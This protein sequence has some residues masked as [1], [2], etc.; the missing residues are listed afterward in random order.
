[1][2]NPRTRFILTI[3]CPLLLITLSAV[4]QRDKKRKSLEGMPVA[5]RM[6]EAES[7][8]TEG[9]K[10]FILEDYAKALY[11]FQRALELN[12]ENATIHYK[13][14]EILAKGNK[15]DDLLRASLSIETALSLEKKNKYFYILASTIYSGLNNFGQAEQAL[16]TMM[17]EIKGTDEYLY[18]LAALYQYDHK[19]DEAIKVYNRAES[20]LGINEISSTQKQ[21][22][23]L[24]QGKVN[25]AI[26]EGKKLVTA[27]PDDERFVLGLAETF[28]QNKQNAQAIAYLENY[29][30]DHPDAGNAK[31]L[32]AGIYR[33]AGE[34]NKARE[35]LLSAFQDASLPVGSKVMMLGAQVAALG[36]A[37]AKKVGDPDGEA[38]LITL[39][40]MLRKS[41]PNDASVNVVGGDLFLTLKKNAEA[42]RE[43]R[44]AIR[45][46]ST[47]FDA[48][49][50]L[51]YLESQQNEFD[52]VIVHAEQALELFPNQA[53][54]YYFDGF[55]Q[56]R[57]RHY[58]EAVTTLEQ[59]KKLS[60]QNPSLAGD[61]SG[62]LGEAYNGSKDYPKSDQ[63]YDDALAVNPDND[64]VLNNYSY[65]LALRK[66]HLDKAEKMSS[67]L[68]R[69]HPENA[70]YL[71][72]YSWVLYERGKYK[73]AKRIMEKAIGTGNLSAT[74]VEHYGDILFQL[75]NIDEAVKQWQ[76]SKEL[77][78]GNALI[79][80]KIANRKLY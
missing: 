67:R 31:M 50:N 48:W 28:S 12:S 69:S 76:K 4:A 11:H 78:N 49:Q 60:T 71:D 27:F 70:T 72:T 41:N 36:Q 22:L 54:I 26:M 35:L 40:E 33:D 56:L 55:A 43:Y 61:V 5:V 74:I 7:A 23:Y 34:E 25:E 19:P 14:A 6:R 15:Q 2:A 20:I 73:D 8:F 1:L 47:S 18:E 17:E 62:L 79:D 29:L 52:S 13:V 38:F 21:R 24:E 44:T 30:K 3:V 53:M 51:L 39:F 16:Q 63:A 64:L 80:K 42:E 59:A 58:R 77:D 66:E 65:Y 57:K 10:Y 68:T 32:L 37:Q 9:E 45:N 46:K 75:G